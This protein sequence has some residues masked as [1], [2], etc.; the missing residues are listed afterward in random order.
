MIHQSD[1]WQTCNLTR[2]HSF[3]TCP[4]LAQHES[5]SPTLRPF[6]AIRGHHPKNCK[7]WRILGRL[8]NIL[9]QV[10]QLVIACFMGKQ[11]T[12]RTLGRIF[13]I[14]CPKCTPPTS[15]YAKWPTSNSK[16]KQPSTLGCHDTSLKSERP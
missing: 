14:L 5:R 13:A 4:G 9:Y 10:S 1:N 15:L 11:M 16:K 2:L 7:T 8:T 3:S 12:C 6:V